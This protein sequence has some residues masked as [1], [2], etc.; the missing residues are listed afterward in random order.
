MYKFSITDHPVEK[1]VVLLVR[2]FKKN[3]STAFP[4]PY[5]GFLQIHSLDTQ[6]HKA[7]QLKNMMHNIVYDSL[8]RSVLDSSFFSCC[9]KRLKGKILFCG[10]I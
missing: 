10:E 3:V 9:C 7:S 2:Q 4:E 6:N 8:L 1:Q 5:I